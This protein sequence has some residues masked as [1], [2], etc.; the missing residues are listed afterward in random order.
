LHKSLNI[1]FDAKRLFSNITGLGNYSRTIVDNLQKH[2][3]NN[4]YTLY[5][6]T[7]KPTT[8]NKFF[9]ENVQLKKVTTK[10]VF[11]N[12]WRSYGIT[13]NFKKNNIQIYHGLS[14]ELPFNIKNY[15][16]KS[17]LTVH[18]LIFEKFPNTYPAIDRIIYRSKLKASCKNADKII[19]ISESTKHDIIEIYN[20]AAQKIEVVYQS[21]NQVFFDNSN[22]T[23]ASKTFQQLKLPLKYLLYVGSVTP[24][25]NLKTLLNALAILKPSLQLPLVIVG[26]GKQ[27]KKQMQQL[28]HQLKINHLLFWLDAIDCNRLLKAI[29]QNA[30]A[31]IYPSIYEGF[32]LPVAEALLCKTPVIT[33]NNSSLKEAGGVNSYYVNVLNKDEIKIAIETVLTNSELTNKMKLKGYD[34]AQQ[35]FN[36]LITAQ[37]IMKVYKKC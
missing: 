18:D 14:N 32:G 34:Y 2:F 29:Y 6:P 9:I 12:Y 31:L 8:F 30:V 13:K 16:T 27:Y 37:N 10:T 23:N 22:N 5:S 26:K 11:K 36:S 17:I 15:K 4:K 7:I 35:N 24:R 21:C 20:I 1:G 19:A 25:K 28:A 3:S 33:G